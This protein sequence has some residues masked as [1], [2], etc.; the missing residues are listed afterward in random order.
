[1]FDYNRYIDEVE[2]GFAVLIWKQMIDHSDG[3]E[4]CI[5]A[6]IINKPWS[7]LLQLS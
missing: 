3:I 1:M 7:Q 5:V 2:N 4:D 6:L